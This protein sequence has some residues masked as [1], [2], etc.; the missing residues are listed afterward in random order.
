MVGAEP[1]GRSL[2]RLERARNIR[3]SNESERPRATV[4]DA[5]HADTPERA[6]PDPVHDS[7]SRQDGPGT[8]RLGAGQAGSRPGADLRA[9]DGRMGK[10]R[11][12]VQGSPASSAREL[13]QEPQAAS[14]CRLLGVAATQPEEMEEE[15]DD[16]GFLCRFEGMNQNHS[17]R[18]FRFC[19]IAIMWMLCRM[20][21][22]IRVA[23]R[24]A[25]ACTDPPQCVLRVR[26]RG[27]P[28]SV[29]RPRLSARPHPVA[30]R[31][32]TPGNIKPR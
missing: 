24:F 15:E 28:R 9:H 4:A 16:D 18:P 30:L 22:N 32:G 11:R 17:I 19:L 14:S 12:G 23:S 1:A 29:L 2:E 13:H 21:Q 10:R 5:G 31:T 8:G 27:L 6:I 3:R 20:R 26:A 25:L 7:G